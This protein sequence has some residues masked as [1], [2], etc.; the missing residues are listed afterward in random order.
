[1]TPT[2]FISRLVQTLIANANSYLMKTSLANFKCIKSSELNVLD[3]NRIFQKS[4]CS[5]D[6]IG[7]LHR[8][9][10]NDEQINTDVVMKPLKH[11]ASIMSC[12]I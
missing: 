5:T 1:M 12:N 3:Y 8:R 7:N 2:P 4:M 10:V 11:F 6:K 9:R